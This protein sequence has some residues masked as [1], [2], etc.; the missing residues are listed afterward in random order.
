ML[1]ALPFSR[2]WNVHARRRQI[3]GRLRQS[4]AQCSPCQRVLLEEGAKEGA[5]V[6]EVEDRGCGQLSEERLDDGRMGGEDALE[7]R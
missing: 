6:V 4:K 7:C 5:G 3:D 2:V 1:F